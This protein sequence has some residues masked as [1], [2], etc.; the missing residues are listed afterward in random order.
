[1]L[2]RFVYLLVLVFCVSLTFMTMSGCAKKEAAQQEPAATVEEQ[3]EETTVDTTQ[4]A[5][6]EAVE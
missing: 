3:T 1:M 4:T 6:E 5:P 2:R